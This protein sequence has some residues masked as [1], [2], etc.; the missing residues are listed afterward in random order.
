MQWGHPVVRS[1]KREAGHD[2]FSLFEKPPE[3]F[4]WRKEAILS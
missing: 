1:P 2:C 4:E 3:D